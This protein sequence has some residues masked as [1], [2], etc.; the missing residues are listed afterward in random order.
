MLINGMEVEKTGSG[1]ALVLV[2]GLGGTGNFWFPQLAALSATFTVYRP[3]MR[4]SGR[5]P[6][7][8]GSSGANGSGTLTVDQIVADLI[9]LLDHEKIDRAAF[10]GH[11]FG[12]LVVQHLA[13]KHP[14]RVTQVALV[15]PVRAPADA[16]RQGPRDRAAKVRAEGMIAVADAIVGAA[17][18]PATRANKP[19]AVSFVREL[20]LRQDPA[21]YA[22]TCEALANAVEV[23]YAAITAPTLLLTGKDD[24]VGS[25]ATAQALRD[26]IADARL[27][28]LDDCGHWTAIEQPERVGEAL[29]DFLK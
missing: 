10:A 18:S 15:G 7:N 29:T 12:S 25:P 5:S 16:N 8:G 23:D 21:G 4:G 13:A 19:I 2:H 11:S 3:D 1:P 28:V 26:L 6:L 22:A 20:L 24:G 9:G 27:T 17:L 14:D